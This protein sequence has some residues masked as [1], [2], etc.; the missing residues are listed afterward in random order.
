[1]IPKIIGRIAEKG[2][3]KIKQDPMKVVNFITGLK[4][5][6]IDLTQIRKFI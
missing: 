2:I 5:S 1:M 4:G 3:E 6:A